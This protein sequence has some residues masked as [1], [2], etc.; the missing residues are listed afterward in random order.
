M[1]TK[2]RG[3]SKTV[4]YFRKGPE[5]D[6]RGV[7]GGRGGCIRLKEEY[8]CNCKLAQQE[9]EEEGEERFLFFANCPPQGA[10]RSF[11]DSA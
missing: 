2:H 6:W 1:L 10:L 3:L 7:E 5:F 11:L 9:Q 8:V 4:G